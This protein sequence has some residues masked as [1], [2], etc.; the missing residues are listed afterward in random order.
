MVGGNNPPIYFMIIYYINEYKLKGEIIMMTMEMMFGENKNILM[1]DS[2]RRKIRSLKLKTV[3]NGATKEEEQSAKQKIQEIESKYKSTQFKSNN[4]DSN[5]KMNIARIPRMNFMENSFYIDQC[6]MPSFFK[7]N[8]GSSDFYV[9]E[10]DRVPFKQYPSY[11][12]VVCKECLN[13]YQRSESGDIYCKTFSDVKELF[14]FIA[15]PYKTD[16][17]KKHKNE[18]KSILKKSEIEDR[19]AFTILRIRYILFRK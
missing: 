16:F 11:K 10:K 5:I 18:I 15:K 4:K 13:K 3:E 12:I 6:I 1:S 9:R 14:T 7:C 8:C 19:L 17:Y 2:D